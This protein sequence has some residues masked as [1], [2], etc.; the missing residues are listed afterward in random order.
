M[1]NH[2]FQNNQADFGQAPIHIG[3]TPLVNTAFRNMALPQNVFYHPLIK[4]EE[5]CFPS[6]MVRFPG[7]RGSNENNGLIGHQNNMVQE[8]TV[9]N[10][11][12]T[13]HSEV[14]N[15]LNSFGSLNNAIHSILDMVKPNTSQPKNLNELLQKSFSS[16]HSNSLLQSPLLSTRPSPL[17]GYNQMQNSYIQN[18]MGPDFSNLLT[19][20]VLGTPIQNSH[21]LRNQGTSTQPSKNNN[22]TLLRELATLLKQDNGENIKAALAEL[23]QQYNGGNTLNSYNK[24][25]ENGRPN[26]LMRMQEELNQNMQHHNGIRPQKTISLSNG[27]TMNSLNRNLDSKSRNFNNGF[28]QANLNNINMGHKRDIMPNESSLKKG[29][30]SIIPEED[31]VDLGNVSFGQKKQPNSPNQALNNKLG[32]LSLNNS[33]NKN[34]DKIETSFLSRFLIDDELSKLFQERISL[35]QEAPGTYDRE[36]RTNKI[37]KYKNKIRKWRVAHP[38]NRN[39][40]G[41]SVV[42]GKKPRIKGKFV[43]MEEYVNY[44]KSENP[45]ENIDNDSQGNENTTYVESERSQREHEMNIKEEPF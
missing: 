20:S 29:N 30:Y 39:F 42:A 24:M 28:R 35:D 11:G 18:Q 31:S 1:N 16:T 36:E 25:R 17:V 34:E 14:L 33:N 23:L 12:L 15:S 22:E 6:P 44:I 10:I 3:G 37:L 5:S 7:F 26:G 13:A 2:S 21:L 43:S 8:N 38:V 45:K 19:S 27:L 9:G 40:K 41:R 32:S 4:G